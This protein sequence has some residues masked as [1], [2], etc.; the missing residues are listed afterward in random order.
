M[1]LNTM[2]AMAALL[3]AGAALTAPAMA[4]KASDTLKLTVLDPFPMIDPFWV[5]ANEANQWNREVF[6][7]FVVYDEYKGQ[8]VGELAKAWR[9]ID[10]KTIEFDLRD[11][12]NFSSGN[13]FTGEDVKYTLEYI[14]DPKVN[15]RFKQRYDWVE[16]VDVISPY[17]VR[18]H[19]KQARPDD[20]EVMAYRFHILDKKVHEKLED[21]Q[22]YGRTTASS[23]G[24]YKLVSIDHNGNVRLTRNDEAVSKLKNI[25][26]PIKNIVGVPVPDRQTQIAQLLT[27]GVHVL[28]KVGPDLLSEFAGNPNF[29]ITPFSTRLLIYVTLDA[30]GRSDNKIFTDKRMREAFIRAVDREKIIKAFVP[31]ADI[32]VRPDAICFSDNIGCAS[33]TKPYAYD[34]EGAKKLLAEAGKPDGFEMELSAFTPYKAVA[35]AIAGDLRRVGI[36][37]TVQPLTIAVYTKLRGD[38][39]LTAL[40]AEYPTFS[41]PNLINIMDVFFGG[42]RDY[43]ND[44]VIKK[45]N[46]E[47]A[48]TL[49]LVKRTEMYKQAMDQVNREAYIMPISEQP[50]LFIHAKDV[51]IKPGLT[52]KTETR[53]GDYFWK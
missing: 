36:R 12:I 4:Q 27:G 42:D 21:K 24:A 23:T 51:E 25:R 15:I 19:A 10:E 41:Q 40:V 5:P 53:P 6:G 7:R 45:I 47:G 17:K 30:A 35:E 28:A 16:R 49:D 31:G 38:G 2:T 52:S 18:V 43:S 13:H 37:A 22:S 48:K 3:I 26:A 39:K 29:S 33:S 46:E 20:I 44:P 1:K 8:F 14:A 34:P 50:N 9:H 32:A 11:D